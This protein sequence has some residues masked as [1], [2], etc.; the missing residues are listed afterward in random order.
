MDWGRR[1]E[2]ALRIAQVALTS[3]SLADAVVAG[4]RA[5]AAPGGGVHRAQLAAVLYWR[6]QQGGVLANLYEA[7]E[8]DRAAVADD[9]E[10]AYK[11]SNFALLLKKLFE[12]AGDPADLAEAETMA[13]RAVALSPHSPA[14]RRML[15]M[16]LRTAFTRTGDQAVLEEAVE[17]SAEALELPDD[18]GDPAHYQYSFALSLADWYDAVRSLDALDEAITAARSAVSL[19]RPGAQDTIDRQ[20]HLCAMLDTRWELTGTAQHKAELVDATTTLAMIS[21]HGHTSRDMAE[22]NLLALQGRD[23]LKPLPDEA[24]LLAAE[25]VRRLAR[26]KQTGEVERLEEG[27]ALARAAVQAGTPIQERRASHLDTLAVALKERVNAVGGDLAESLDLHRQAIELDPC[28]R[29]LSNASGT[30]LRIFRANGEFAL[31]D[32]AIE[33]TRAA[34]AQLPDAANLGMLAVCLNHRYEVTGELAVL[35]EAITHARAATRQIDEGDAWH[36]AA[37]LATLLYSWFARTGELAGLRECAAMRETVL[38]GVPVRHPKR[39]EHLCNL[40]AVQHEIFDRSGDQKAL[41]AAITA[42]RAA[43]ELTPEWHQ[44]RFRYLAGLSS[45]MVAKGEV[46]EG[47]S[48]ARQALRHTDPYHRAHRLMVLAQ[49]LGAEHA[50]TADPATLTEALEVLRTASEVAVSP[51]EERLGA[52]VKWGELAA[53]TG[54]REEAAVAMAT[55]VGLLPRL[56]S[57]RLGRGDAQH[58]LRRFTGLAGKAAACALDAGGPAAAVV[59]LEVGRGVLSAQALDVREDL[60]ALREDAP[61]LAQRFDELSEAIEN[62]QNADRVALSAAFDEVLNGIRAVPGHEDFLRRP[63]FA[64]LVDV[65]SEGPVVLVNTSPTRCDALILTPDEVLPVTLPAL[66]DAELRRRVKAFHTGLAEQENSARELA[67]LQ[68]LEWLWHAVVRPVVA[69]LPPAGAELPRVWWSP[70]GPLALLPLHAAGVHGGEWIGDHMISSYTTTIR[71]LRYARRAPSGGR[72]RQLIVSM[73]KTPGDEDLPNAEREAAAVAMTVP[74]AKR[75]SADEANRAAVVR[76][77]ADRT[78]A[79]FACHG[80]ADP[81]DPSR[82]CLALFDGPLTVPEI[83]RLRLADAEFA[84]LSACDTARAEPTLSDEAI[85][86]AGAFQTAGFRHVVGTQWAVND[87]MARYAAGLVYDEVMG[88]GE[89][90]A[91]R[92]AAALHSVQAALREGFPNIPS[93]WATFLHAGA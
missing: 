77:L 87:E 66:S 33:L 81:A 56:A 10:N 74:G 3:K 63:T 16:V 8:L 52:A 13:R 88:E 92:S 14:Y 20:A 26:Y 68:T 72:P 51:V 61:A 78:W 43:V 38:A 48:L 64:E 44:D 18:Q 53:R 69:A 29:H 27:I 59:V 84:Y 36:N 90:D 58:F 50:L 91:A 34:V 4:R 67:V 39:A 79:H 54:R 7:R 11:A 24:E 2:E 31:V 17:L 46:G 21:P 19:S 42:R 37:N 6:Y 80:N 82:S 70:V 86:L 12:E 65:A 35:E 9:P 83:A 15:S 25:A 89:P 75:L 73:P 30:L 5:V 41:N 62:D 76:A 57:R 40:A 49:A 93:L 45:L 47:V 1:F 55:A 22:R 71:A 28:A 32:K 85:H 23:P 60:S